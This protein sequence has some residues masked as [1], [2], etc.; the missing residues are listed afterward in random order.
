MGEITDRVDRM[1]VR[2][3]SPDNNIMAA[4]T[5]GRTLEIQF[6][7]GTYRAYSRHGLQHQL[8][9]LGPLVF[10]GYRRGLNQVIQ[11]V[12]GSTEPASEDWDANRRRYRQAQ[13]K[14]VARAFSPNRRL[15][16]QAE[17]LLHW[18]V[19]IKDGT[20]AELSEADF[21]REASKLVDRVLNDHNIKIGELQKRHL[22]LR[23]PR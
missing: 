11:S 22:G 18:T 13:E 2:A 15:R 16:A 20:L 17:G 9:Q 3:T 1:V 6:R 4:F 14:L 7:P 21:C 23:A 10:T 12:T 8:S 19:E 5:G